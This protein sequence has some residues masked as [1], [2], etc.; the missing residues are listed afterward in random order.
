MDYPII[1][2]NNLIPGQRY[3]LSVS[4][5]MIHSGQ[6]CGDYIIE[7]LD[8]KPQED[9]FTECVVL[10]T[11]SCEDKDYIGCEVRVGH[12]VSNFQKAVEYAGI[13][14]AEGLSQKQD[15]LT[16]SDE[17]AN[18]LR[19]QE[20]ETN[21]INSYTREEFLDE[22]SAWDVENTFGLEFPEDVV[23]DDDR[24]DFYYNAFIHRLENK[25]WDS[26]KAEET[27]FE[28]NSILSYWEDV[29]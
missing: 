15:I 29:V 17:L 8:V 24:D 1:N 4:D 28:L 7:A 27:S 26:P 16:Y 5:S 9:G 13:E 10:E 3:I 18:H 20:Q 11:I 25:L 14:T 6:S 22:F 2:P 19:K 23:D 12:Y 21:I